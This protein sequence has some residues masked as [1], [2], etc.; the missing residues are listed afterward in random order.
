MVLQPFRPIE[1]V[2]IKWTRLPFHFRVALRG[3]CCVPSQFTLLW[4]FWR[5]IC[6]GVPFD[7]SPVFP[8]YP[9]HAFFRVLFDHLMPERLE[10]QV[11]ASLELLRGHDRSIVLRPAL[12]NRVELSDD[13]LL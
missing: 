1:Q 4:S 8:F 5:R 6:P 11:V 10:K 7:G 13:F 3:C 12:K 2:S 9:F